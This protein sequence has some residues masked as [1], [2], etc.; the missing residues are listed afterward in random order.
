MGV[1]LSRYTG[2][3]TSG[4]QIFS[5]LAILLQQLMMIMMIMMMMMMM[6]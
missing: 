3:A 2:A 5:R 1:T 6:K 4:G